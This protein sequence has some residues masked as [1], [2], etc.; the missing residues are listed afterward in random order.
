MHELSIALGIID[1]GEEVAQREGSTSVVAVHLK[2]GPLAGVVKDALVSA[3]ELA[4]EG[5][6][7]RPR[8][9]SSRTCRSR[10]GAARCERQQIVES[11]QNLCCQQCGAPTPDIVSGRELEVVAM[12]FE[13]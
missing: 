3:F 8:A 6:I 13:A 10:P 2:L 7:L 4:R 9:W 5:S 11:L 12:E 1:I